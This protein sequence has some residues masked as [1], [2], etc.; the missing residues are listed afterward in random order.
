MDE[1]NLNSIGVIWRMDV[2]T[3]RPDVHQPRLD[4][5]NPV[6]ICFIQLGMPQNL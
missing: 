3:R 2:S 5:P 1:R 6:K 4:N